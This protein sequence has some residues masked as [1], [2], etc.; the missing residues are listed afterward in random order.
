MKRRVLIWSIKGGV[1]KTSIALNLHYTTNIPVITNEEYSLLESVIDSKKKLKIL[2][3]SEDVPS[4][5]SNF[6]II[7]DFA[8]GV[9]RDKRIKKAIDQVNTVIIPI[10]PRK[11]DIKGGLATIRE[12]ESYGI[13]NRTVIILINNYRNKDELSKIEA[14]LLKMI[15]NSSLSKECKVC[16]LKQ[17]KALEMIY[18][19]KKSI[20]E[21]RKSDPLLGH[22]FRLVDNDFYKLLKFIKV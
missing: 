2:K 16:K 5:P 20:R 3:S 4:I 19:K 15:K 9:H 13:G 10:T 1:G 17:S 8:G 7:F 21:I 18:D 22:S 6:D 11:A 14:F 12:L